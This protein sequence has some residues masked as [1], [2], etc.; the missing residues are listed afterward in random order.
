MRRSQIVG[1]RAR[2]R[3]AI[4][5]GDEAEWRP[6][7]AN[8]LL[9]SANPGLRFAAPWAMEYGPVGAERYFALPAADFFFVGLTVGFVPVLALSAF[10]FAAASCRSQAVSQSSCWGLR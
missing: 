7:G 6:V 3:M 5:L 10:G 8:G 2:P 1:M 4:G 9:W